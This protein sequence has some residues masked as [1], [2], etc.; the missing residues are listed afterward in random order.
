MAKVNIDYANVPSGGPAGPRG[1]LNVDMRTGAGDAFRSAG[2][3]AQ[4]GF[5][6]ALTMHKI[7]GEAELVEL[8]AKS[9]E[10]LNDMFQKFKA[11]GNE[12]TYQQ[13]FEDTWS[14]IEGLEAKNGW[15]RRRRRLMLTQAKPGIQKAVQKEYYDRIDERKHAAVGVA[16][17]QAIR[18]NNMGLLSPLLSSEVS[19]GKMTEEEADLIL[20]EARR[21]GAQQRLAMMASTDPEHIRSWNNAEEMMKEVPNSIPTD[22]AWIQGVAQG[23]LA[24]I[25]NKRQAE[26]DAY[27][28]GA[29]KIALKEGSTLSDLI[30][31][32]ET[33]DLTRKEKDEILVWGQNRAKMIA[34]GNPDPLKVRQD[35]GVYRD[36]LWKV[37]DGKAITEDLRKAVNSNQISLGDY[38]QLM[39]MKE[40]V[41]G[42]Y[43]EGK[44]L[45]Q[46]IRNIE[47]LF[48]SSIPLKFRRDKRETGK[49][50]AIELL[51]ESVRARKELA[52]KGQGTP[53]SGSELTREAVRIQRMV[54]AE[55]I[56]AGGVEEIYST[57]VPGPA[58][59]PIPQG[60]ATSDHLS[61][62]MDDDHKLWPVHDYEED[63]A[64]AMGWM[65]APQP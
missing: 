10:M 6:F 50:K 43:G 18:S 23:Q 8:G 20:T 19:R 1:T 33:L 42:S 9:E 16:E 28:D 53:L 13:T 51:T 57:G 44:E 14:Q 31:Y 58:P 45:S 22:F 56:R 63:M 15:A 47:S 38:Q 41:A 35:N 65:K 64:R 26:V 49:I 17:A 5:N 39:N 61:L 4:E 48:D 40:H 55:A 29:W 30:N 21:K 11:S 24:D 25:K 32:T 59:V 27:Y 60:P 62:W 37:E 7:Q 52:L 3:F 46:A 2:R 34:D 12:E 36:L 54:L